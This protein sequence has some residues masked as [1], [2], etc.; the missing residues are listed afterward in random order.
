ME[1]HSPE[2]GGC[3]TPTADGSE[4]E[5]APSRNQNNRIIQKQERNQ[6]PSP[7][8]T[9]IRKVMAIVASEDSPIAGAALGQ[10]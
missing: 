6:I 9:L 2:D 5:A 3:K 4:G 1:E 8:P 7:F 10:S